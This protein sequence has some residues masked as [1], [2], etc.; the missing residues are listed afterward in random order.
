MLYDFFY[1]Q[2]LRRA[3]KSNVQ[4]HTLYMFSNLIIHSALFG[5]SK[6][7]RTKHEKN[8]RVFYTSINLQW[9]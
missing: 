9:I 5:V 3:I 8:Y 2:L 6:L 1:K 4:F 7:R